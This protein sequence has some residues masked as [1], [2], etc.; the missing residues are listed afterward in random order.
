MVV[1]V[2]KPD[3]CSDGSDD[4]EDDSG[5][6]FFDGACVVNYCLYFWVC[7]GVGDLVFPGV[8]FVWLRVCVVCPFDAVPVT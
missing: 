6:D 1:C 2:F 4:D 5:D 7:Y 3:F 8:R